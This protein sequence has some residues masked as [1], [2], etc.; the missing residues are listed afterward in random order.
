MKK[1]ISLILAALFIFS[2]FS[3]TVLAANAEIKVSY[4]GKEIDFRY[5]T[6]VK[7]GAVMC[8]AG[9]LF[10]A[11][12]MEYTFNAMTGEY[13]GTF[14]QQFEMSLTL[15]SNI[16]TMDKVDVE[17]PVPAYKYKDSAMVPL[18]I[19][20]YIFN[21]D[22]DDSN[23]ADIKLVY[24]R[25]AHKKVE[26][27]RDDALREATEKYSDYKT[28][29]IGG[30]LDF[31]YSETSEFQGGECYEVT[32]VA[33]DDETL[34]FDEAAHI[35]GTSFY[36]PPYNAQMKFI[37]NKTTT[38]RDFFTLSFWAKGVKSDAENGKSD[39][40]VCFETVGTWIKLLLVDM[41]IE[42]EWTKYEY[43]LPCEYTVPQLQLCL[44]NN[45][46]NLQEIMVADIKVD[47]YHNLP[48]E[49]EP[50]YPP[51]D[52]KGIEEDALWR[53]EALKRI[54]KIR[55]NNMVVNVVDES[56]NP[57]EGAEVKFD[58]TEHE[59]LWG[60]AVYYISFLQNHSGNTDQAILDKCRDM[61]INYIVEGT[62]HK[63]QVFTPEY[64]AMVANWCKE[65]GIPFR[66]HAPYWEIDDIG[67]WM[68]PHM[69]TNNWDYRYVDKETLRKRIEYQYNSIWTWGVQNNPNQLDVVNEISTRHRF[70]LSPL[71][72]DEMARLFEM[73][74]QIM[75]GVKL[76]ANEI[77]IGFYDQD[78]VV[79]RNFNAQ[80]K[81]LYEIG[82]PVDGAGI[83]G[84]VYRDVDY[85]QNWYIN[86]NNWGTYVSELSVTEYDSTPENENN[87]GPM[88]RDAMIATFSHPKTEAFIIW[89]PWIG[90][91]NDNLY[92]QL[93]EK[94]G[95]VVSE[96]GRMFEQLVKH[97]WMTHETVNTDKNGK[98][99]VR[100]F[101]GRYDVKVKAGNKEETIT[102][103]L[104]EDEGKNVVNAV[105]SSEGIKLTSENLYIP[106]PKQEY[107][108]GRN[109]GAL[110][111]VD[112]PQIHYGVHR[113]DILD[114]KD[115][116]GKKVEEVFDEN[117][118]TFWTQVDKNDTLT[119]EI[120]ELSPLK[121]L[122]ISWHDGSIKRYSRKIEVSDD[123]ES[124]TTVESGKNATLDEKIDL[125][126]LKGKYI[127]ISG[128]DGKLAI[129]EI[130]IFVD[131]VAIAEERRS[132]K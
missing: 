26:W 73:A 64:V 110:T 68:M 34:P 31:F 119:M 111:E 10:D 40:G 51:A 123:G 78:H 102:V 22:M 33:V 6:V 129:D 93:L 117:S 55:K 72:V 32:K 88:L 35:K 82:A 38:D 128:P 60:M 77:T 87:K 36:D 120:S 74:R 48:E 100:G 5:P 4:N 115:A 46:T 84:H 65:E 59:F 80:L 58:M 108:D 105:V 24:D 50:P 39:L 71:G 29:I 52:Y 99:E 41:E 94:G 2:V 132:G 14:E 106:E 13:K 116:K 70:L 98:A 61:G 121:H 124:W 103:N 130:Q 92:A 3:T 8:E 85:P 107:T 113:P 95:T 127:R 30:G 109:W 90:D 53:K 112:I 27:N 15:G 125:M 81:Y 122:N 69:H 28:E 91:P 79:T 37:I 20:C 62:R 45:L 49:Y 43:V 56:G 11:I 63:A 42:N 23:P 67:S 18:D 83:Q 47:W 54:D 97:E 44:R 25:A 1:I 101:R 86:M 118:K 104:T 114:A 16:I 19:I 9:G 75:P 21:I 89:S 57:V 131:E 12:E 7:D 96:G 76:Y 66:A 126:P 17:M